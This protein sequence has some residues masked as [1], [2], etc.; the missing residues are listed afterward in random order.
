MGLECK[1]ATAFVPG[2]TFQCSGKLGTRLRKVDLDL[3]VTVR[4]RV[5]GTQG[6]RVGVELSMEP[7]TR[8]VLDK[9]VREYEQEA[10]KALNLIAEG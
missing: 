10:I 3:T 5:E 2:A 1:D 9:L 7:G 6:M 4:W 8:E